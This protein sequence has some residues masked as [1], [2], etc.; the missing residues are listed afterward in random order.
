MLQVFT[1]VNFRMMYRTKW[2]FLAFSA[3]TM[4]VSG[5]AMATRG[6]NYGIDFAGG[7]AVQLKFREAPR[8]QDLRSAL[9][10]AGLGD[11]SI[12]KIGG[13]ED[14]E[15][16]I[17]VE[18][19]RVKGA[20]AG[21]EGGEISTEILES[22]KTPEERA[23]VRSGKID[24]NMASQAALQEWLASRLPNAVE[25]AEAVVRYRTDHQGLL[26]S[27][28]AIASI[29][30]VPPEAAAL[31]SA[32]STV[33]RF[34]LR[35]VDFVGPTA[36]RELLHNTAWLILLS[37][38]GILVYVWFRFHKW[39]WGVTAVIALVHTVFIAAGMISLTG[40]EFSL[41]VVAALLTVL[42]Y[43]INDTIVVFDRIRENLRL[44]REH[45]FE[46]VVNA[47]VN[48]TLSRTMLTS[49][50]LIFAIVAFLM[51]GGDK[52]N[53]MMFCLLVGLCFG[54]YASVFV[55]AALLVIA[56]RRFGLKYVKA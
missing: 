4:V 3:L 37:V 13:A 11:V 46:E 49:L 21:G 45:E 56:Y 31:L 40:K 53:P 29:P 22:L 28:G 54:T 15:V 43:S 6:F 51:F 7:T 17:R 8:V 9:E 41:T 14:N 2:Y 12:Q 18:Q 47:S 50:S 42:G 23:A 26:S 35:S 1:H 24:L 30:G 20:A 10:Q 38:L 27:P 5:W 32:E 44:Y 33:G 19:Q 48:Q 39:T 36:G 25:V 55:A 34:A 16:L 52:L